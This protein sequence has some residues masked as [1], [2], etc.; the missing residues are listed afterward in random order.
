VPNKEL[1]QDVVFFGS[2]HGDST[3]KFGETGIR[4]LPSTK[5]KSPL[6]ADATINMECMLHKEVDAGDHYIY[7]GEIVAAHADMDKKVLFNTRKEGNTRI[8]KE[9]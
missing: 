3:D 2:R 4:T 7:I 9:F 6:L 8:F 1:K 5:V